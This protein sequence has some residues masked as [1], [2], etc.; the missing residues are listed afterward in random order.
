LYLATG[1]KDPS[2]AVENHASLRHLDY[3]SLLLFRTGG[4]IIAAFKI[5]QIK[6]PPRQ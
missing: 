1:G 6:T 5:L 3:S 2:S 4:N